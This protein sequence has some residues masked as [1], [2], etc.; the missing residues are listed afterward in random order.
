MIISLGR[1]PKIFATKNF[2]YAINERNKVVTC[3]CPR[4]LHSSSISSKLVA[5]TIVQRAAI[6]RIIDQK[7]SLLVASCRRK[8]IDFR[9][10]ACF[11]RLNSALGIQNRRPK[12]LLSQTLSSLKQF[13]LKQESAPPNNLALFAP[14]SQPSSLSQSF[15]SSDHTTPEISPLSVRMLRALLS[16]TSLKIATTNANVQGVSMHRKSNRQ[17][18]RKRS[19]V[20]FDSSNGQS[21]YSSVIEQPLTTQR[22]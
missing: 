11:S 15:R 20:L 18:H 4:H 7:P 21:M 8:S 16:S 19:T 5:Y 22:N 1:C 2:N 3:I 14:L 9:H 10:I 17:H 13:L 12:S 6:M